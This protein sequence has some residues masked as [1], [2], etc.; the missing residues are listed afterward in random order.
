[1]NQSDCYLAKI[2]VVDDTPDSLNALSD[3]LESEGYQIFAAPSGKIALKVVDETTPDL[4]LLDVLM[5]GID[6]LETCRQL[7]RNESTA[8]I[9]VI[10]IT[11]KGDTK[12]V[13]RG[14]EVGGVSDPGGVVAEGVEGVADALE[15]AGAVVDNANVHPVLGQSDQ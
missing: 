12:D 1:M 9:P 11:A 15:I 5:P 13:L 6:G 2:L 8:T 3:T 4:I 14:F 10:F 7:K